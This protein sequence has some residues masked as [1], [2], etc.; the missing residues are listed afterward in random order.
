MLHL[1]IINPVAGGSNKSDAIRKQITEVFARKDPEQDIAVI[2]ETNR[3][4]H[5]T[6][7]VRA[8]D[9]GKPMR[10]YACGGDGT[11]NEIVNAAVN[12][13]H[14]EVAHFP[15]GS[16]N[17]FIKC[18]EDLDF[19]WDIEA[20]TDGKSVEVDVIRCNGRIALNT[21]CTGF[22]ANIARDMGYFRRKKFLTGKTA[23]YASIML[24]FFGKI[25]TPHHI[26]A[27]GEIYED[28]HTMIA[29]M[30]GK[31]YGGG[32]CPVPGAK[33]DDGLLECVMVKKV[34]HMEV[35]KLIDHY[36]HGRLDMAGEKIKHIKAKRIEI[37]SP[38][39]IAI[40]HDGEVSYG[41]TIEAEVVPRAVRF[42]Y[43]R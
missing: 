16:G 37:T 33:Q 17:D 8:H 7:I 28:L 26:N 22:D 20:Q 39:D 21:I 40:C 31:Y 29:L 3:R 36:K 15:S 42:I 9:K 24:N 18:Y 10:V 35:V 38:I 6:G 2:I 32:F 13:K 41:R 27:D 12:R 43:G 23:Y 5:A 4:G 34:S 30:N 25:G 11:L 1:F 19:F 14:I